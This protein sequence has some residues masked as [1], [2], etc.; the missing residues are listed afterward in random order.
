MVHVSEYSMYCTLLHAASSGVYFTLMPEAD[1][2]PVP[3]Q[4]SGNGFCRVDPPYLHVA[5]IALRILEP[6]ASTSSH[7]TGPFGA[8]NPPACYQSLPFNSI[9][10]TPKGDR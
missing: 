5:I 3:V 4:S 7:A 10:H 2:S 9:S 1:R 8:N 6:S